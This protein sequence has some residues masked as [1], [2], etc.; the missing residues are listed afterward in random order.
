MS[1]EIIND[2]DIPRKMVE[3]ARLMEN[4]IKT[5]RTEREEKIK[6]GLLERR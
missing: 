2:E 1:A 5:R 6:E 3:I 4:Q